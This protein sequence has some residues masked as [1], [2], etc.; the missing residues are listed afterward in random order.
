MFSGDMLVEASLVCTAS[1]RG[2]SWNHQYV[3]WSFM[4]WT[5]VH[6]GV[7][8]DSV[9]VLTLLKGYLTF[10]SSFFLST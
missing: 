4:N 10:L 9:L 5:G 2:D 1:A 6:V 8:M 7:E 3:S